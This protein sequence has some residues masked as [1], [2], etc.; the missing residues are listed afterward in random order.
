MLGTALYSAYRLRKAYNDLKPQF[1]TSDRSSPIHKKFETCQRTITLT[2]Y[3]F[4]PL[5]KSR[6]WEWTK[7]E[8]TV[9]QLKSTDASMEQKKQ[10]LWEKLKIETFTRLICS[11]YSLPLLF[12]VVS[13]KVAL[14]GRYLTEELKVPFGDISSTPSTGDELD[15]LFR[16]LRNLQSNSSIDKRTQ[17]AYLDVT[18]LDTFLNFQVE[19]V[20][21][22]V[23]QA[24]AHT[25]IAQTVDMEFW[26]SLIVAI[27]EKVETKAAMEE[28]SHS[29]SEVPILMAEQELHMVKNGDL[30]F[31]G[32]NKD[33]L[34]ALLNETMDI[35]EGADFHEVLLEVVEILFEN[36]RRH[37]SSSVEKGPSI[38]LAQ[39]LPKVQSIVSQLF[40]D[41]TSNTYIHAMSELDCV[42]NFAALIFLSGEK[43]EPS[44]FQ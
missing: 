19:R 14:L 10:E 28:N 7:V 13:L 29:F 44:E 41:S 43:H 22:S 27:R 6:L 37:I 15:K 34:V 3:S 32:I 39:L 40:V 25:N 12:T 42:E 31:N 30:E 18:C 11:A 17:Q 2:T 24:L 38:N 35:I 33:S 16:E 8:D 21:K 20:R 36:V 4:L 1:D 5:L 9:R 23:E 26:D